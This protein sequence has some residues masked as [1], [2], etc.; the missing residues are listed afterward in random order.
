MSRLQHRDIRCVF[1]L[2]LLLPVT[3]ACDTPVLPPLPA[4]NVYPFQL[5]TTPPLTLRWPSGATVRVFIVDGGAAGASL[6]RSSFEAGAAAWNQ[7]ALTDEYRL[8]FTDDLRDAD[9]LLAWSDAPLPVDTDGCERAPGR[10]VTTFCVDGDRLHRYPLTSGAPGSVRMLVTI[11]AQLAASPDIT[12]ASVAHELGHV[13][14][15][16]RHSDEPTDLL[17]HGDPGRATPSARDVATVRALYRTT[18]DVLP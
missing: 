6:L 1:L 5:P 7:H 4:A 14:G 16:V 3:S 8:A 15:V 17:W 2:T 13:L 9:V 12:R 11:A 10:G 18:A